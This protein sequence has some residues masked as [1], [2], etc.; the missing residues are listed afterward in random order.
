MLRLQN[1][2]G[3]LVQCEE[4]EGGGQGGGRGHGGKDELLQLPQKLY[5]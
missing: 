2:L 3:R 1:C 4:V 5:Q